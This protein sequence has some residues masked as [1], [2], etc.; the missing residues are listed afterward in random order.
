MEKILQ[1]LNRMQAD[2]VIKKYAIG[3]GIAAVYYLE[4]HA[5]D[6]IDVFIS[7]VV[8]QSSPV[9]LESVYGCLE[10]LA[11]LP[12]KEGVMIEDWLVQFVPAFASVQEEAI[13]QA[14]RVAY[15][16]TETF[17]FS[18]EHLAAE[19]LRSGRP[20]DQLWVID[21]IESVNME[22]KMFLDIINR[23]GLAEKWEQFASR[24]DLEE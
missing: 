11:Y 14:Q 7:P 20:K 16:Q 6:D 18:A 1:V 15:G 17:I 2:G 4:P 22:M 8:G 5:T 13:A 9:S 3:G 10:K 19:F 24:L 21:L 12:A 23:H